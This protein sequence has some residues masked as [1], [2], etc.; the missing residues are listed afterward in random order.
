MGVMSML[1]KCGDKKRMKH[2]MRVRQ[3]LNVLYG[4]QTVCGHEVQD[5]VSTKGRPCYTAINTK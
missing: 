4:T 5:C 1:T 2:V 3:H